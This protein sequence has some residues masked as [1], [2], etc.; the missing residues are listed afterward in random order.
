MPSVIVRR[1]DGST[2]AVPPNPYEVSQL[3]DY[4]DSNHSE[5]A[6][7]IWT[8]N[9]DL[10]PIYA[11]RPRLLTQRTC[12]RYSVRR[13]EESPCQAPT[14]TSLASLGVRGPYEQDG[15]VVFRPDCASGQGV[16][17]PIDGQTGIY[18]L[19]SI[20]VSKS[21]FCRMDSDCWDV[22]LTFFDPENDRRARTVIQ[23]T[24]DVSDEMPVSLAPIRF[25]VDSSPLSIPSTLSHIFHTLTPNSG[26]L[27]SLKVEPISPQLDR[28]LEHFWNT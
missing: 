26:S 28:F 10:T 1:P 23:L 6:K 25:F 20:S 9:L 11:V 3:L 21:P 22:Q 5:S 7:L 2:V 15:A 19:D 4:L 17:T 27:L 14:T 24:V 16:V 8:L 12:T 13:S 18:T